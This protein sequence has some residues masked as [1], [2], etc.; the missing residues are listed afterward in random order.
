M[1][2]IFCILFLFSSLA[3]AKQYTF[4]TDLHI[5][6][7][8]ME[9]KIM[10]KT[11]GQVLSENAYALGDI[12]E[13]KHTESNQCINMQRDFDNFKNIFKNRYVTGN[14]E[15]TK[16]NINLI[17]NEHIL[18]THGDYPM[19]GTNKANSFRE[20]KKKCKGSSLIQKAIANNHTPISKSDE[21]ALYDYA[22]YYNVDTIIVGHRHVASIFDKNINGVRIIA[23]PRGKTVLNL[24]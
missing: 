4:Y 20:D 2:Y 15:L 16:D 6:S 10:P 11:Q 24:D 9:M 12:W 23:L 13:V 22:K 14:H 19:G 21:Q 8:Y 7:I 5:Y 3:Q 18:L 17:I 1:R